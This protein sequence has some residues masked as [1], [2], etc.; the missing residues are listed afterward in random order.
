MARPAEPVTADP[1]IVDTGPLPDYLD[2]DHPLATFTRLQRVGLHLERLQREAI[3]DL[4]IGPTDFV[5]LASLRRDGEPYRLPVTRIAQLVMQ[6][7]GGI[8]QRIDRLERRGLVTRSL[9]SDDRRKVLVQLTPAGLDL[10]VQG[11]RAYDRIRQRV[12][13]DVP[14]AQWAEIDAAVRVLYAAMERDAL[15]R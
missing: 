14:P 3:A 11:G 1:V 8:S 4:D 10:A 13:A 5:V 6:P 12:L 2:S 9:A 7:M 15:G